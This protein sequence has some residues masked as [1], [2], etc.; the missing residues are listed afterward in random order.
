[1]FRNIDS[2][3]FT[4][5]FD[6]LRVELVFR[7]SL[8]VAMRSRKYDNVVVCPRGR[9]ARGVFYGPALRSS[10]IE[11]INLSKPGQSGRIFKQ[12]PEQRTVTDPH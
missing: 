3:T 8:V 5:N 9:T 1:M 2:S 7:M 11:F 4:S 12:M 10:Q 6:V